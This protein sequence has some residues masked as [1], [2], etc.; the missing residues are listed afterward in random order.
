MVGTALLD[1]DLHADAP[2]IQLCNSF[3]R[4]LCFVACN[5]HLV[6]NFHNNFPCATQ[7]SIKPGIEKKAH[8]EKS[9]NN[10][11]VVLVI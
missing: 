9:S 11:C 7:C 10:L 6:K 2:L 3:S 1:R 8:W 4:H 5:R